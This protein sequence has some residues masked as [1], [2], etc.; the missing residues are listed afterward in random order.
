MMLLTGLKSTPFQSEDEQGN[1]WEAE[2][3]WAGA[4]SS[5][6]RQRSQKR[7]LPDKS[8]D[9]GHEADFN[10]FYDDQEV[11]LDDS[12]SQGKSEGPVIVN[13]PG[14]AKK[15]SASLL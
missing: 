6:G 12:G 8:A 9:T 11:D 13:L 14:S 7:L 2:D 5:T 3:N 4:Q 10:Q 1:S 15:G